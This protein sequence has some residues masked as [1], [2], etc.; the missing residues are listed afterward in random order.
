MRVSGAV[1][2]SGLL[3]VVWGETA[4]TGDLAIAEL[5]AFVGGLI[6]VFG[7]LAFAYCAL[8]RDW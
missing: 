8:R 1:P 7:L 3:L 4:D 6:V 2:A 5:V